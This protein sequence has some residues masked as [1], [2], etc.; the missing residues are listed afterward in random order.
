MTTYTFCKVETVDF[1]G[2]SK[3]ED[4]ALYLLMRSDMKSLNPGKACAQAHHAGTKVMCDYYKGYQKLHEESLVERW[5]VNK[6]GFSTVIVL[7]VDSLEELEY[8]I[9]SADNMK[10]LS[11][12]ILDPT[13]PI[14]DG[15]FIHKIPVVSCGYIIAP[16]SEVNYLS[17]LKLM[18]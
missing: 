16:R 12:K 2:D 8:L 9:K 18:R 6:C 3:E 15:E 17:H 10:H 11:G 7:S 13:Y 5:M 14:K 4:V 1:L